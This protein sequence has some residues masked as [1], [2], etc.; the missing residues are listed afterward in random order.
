MGRNEV[1]F[2]N[3]I[4]FQGFGKIARLNRDIV[5][6]EKIDGTNA[7]IGI[8]FYS[9][10][11]VPYFVLPE[12]DDRVRFIDRGGRDVNGMV[13]YAVVYA[14][15][16]KRVITPESDNFG[17]A[18]WV[19]DNAETLVHDLGEGLHFGEWWGSGI[20]RGYGLEKGDKRF[21]LFNVK[22]WTEPCPISHAGD[23]VCYLPTYFKTPKLGVVPVLYRGPFDMTN[24]NEALTNLGLYGSQASPGFDRPEGVIV[25]HTAANQLFKVTLVGDEK[26]K[27]QINKLGA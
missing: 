14:Q 25:Y 5:V 22:R 17:F 18:R 27:S 26:P 12:R 21:S 1:E 2:M 10:D 15:S 8:R 20:Q 13:N 11:L 7:A 9:L 24:I 23:E 6:T 19:W 4:E 3:E 16:R